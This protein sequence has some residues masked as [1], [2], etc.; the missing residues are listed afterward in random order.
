MEE[1]VTPEEVD[2]IAAAV[3]KRLLDT[4]LPDGD[5]VRQSIRQAGDTKA[6]AAETLEQVRK[7]KP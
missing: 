7:L 5:T 2:R 1:P 6:I 4:K 3:V